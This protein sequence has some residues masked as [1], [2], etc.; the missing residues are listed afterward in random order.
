MTMN[1]DV[2]KFKEWLGQKPVSPLP[3][4]PANVALAKEFLKQKW[5]ERAAELGRPAPTDMSN[6]CK[7][8]SMFAMK[9]FGGEMRGNFHHQFLVHPLGQIDLTNGDGVQPEHQRQHDPAF[10]G[11][12]D[13]AASMGTCVD[14]VNQWL[15]DFDSKSHHTAHN[16]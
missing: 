8:A 1:A 7:F 9:L 12:E 13:H 3:P 6:A 4:T 5:L 16:S 15:K 11:N 2:K 14:R 10:W